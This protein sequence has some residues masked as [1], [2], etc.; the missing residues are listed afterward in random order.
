MQQLRG[1]ERAGGDDHLAPRADLLELLALAV[2][3]ADRALALEQDAGRMRH[4]LD[5]QIGAA[6]HM[7]MDVGARRAPA[8]AVL[9]RHLVDAEALVLLGIEILAQ[10]KLRFLR[11][12]QKNLLHRIVGAQPVDRERSA[13][14]VIL[15]AEIGIVFRALEV[16][17]HV[18]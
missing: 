17:Q 1:L 4:G 12:L 18:G 3:D 6:A 10:S 9:L 7:R 5:A 11:R 14:A 2:F 8:F 15:A 16:G 13:L